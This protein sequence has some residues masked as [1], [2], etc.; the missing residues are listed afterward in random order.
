MAEW[1]Q[2]L[3]LGLYAVIVLCQWGQEAEAAPGAAPG[4]GIQ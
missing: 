1:G 2:A 4:L 3:C